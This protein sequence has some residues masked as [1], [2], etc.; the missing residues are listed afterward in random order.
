[1]LKELKTVSIS[2]TKTLTPTL[3]EAANQLFN[4]P[5]ITIRTGNKPNIYIILNK[6]DDKN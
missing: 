6:T 3:K 5:D 2:N 4:N 1:M